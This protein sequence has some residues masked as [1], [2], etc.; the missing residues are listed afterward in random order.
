MHR[1][2]SHLLPRAG[3][4]SGIGQSLDISITPDTTQPSVAQERAYARAGRSVLPARESFSMARSTAAASPQL[5][6]RSASP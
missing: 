4:P 3:M 6:G 5:R 2:S 1:A